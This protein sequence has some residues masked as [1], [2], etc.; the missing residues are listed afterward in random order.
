MTTVLTFGSFDHIHQGHIYYLTEAKKLGDKLFVVVARDST[1][2]KVKGK[3]PKYPEQERLKHLQD[4][5]IADKIVLGY[6]DDVYRVLDDVMPDIIC[7]GYDQRAFVDQL[8][9]ELKKRNFKPKIIRLK[10]YME[11]I[12]KS[13][14]LK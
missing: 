10:P 3:K 7:L 1:I 8:E 11:N 4:L 14:K 5:Q 12:Y 9:E 13:S 6:A 2:E